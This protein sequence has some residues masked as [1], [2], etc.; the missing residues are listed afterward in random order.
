MATKNSKKPTKAKKPAAKKVTKV[1]KTSKES[2]CEETSKPVK[3]AAAAK[4]APK[5][6]AVKVSASPTDF[7]AFLKNFQPYRSK[8]SEKYMNKNQQKHF[9][10]MLTAW[11][12]ALIE[13]QEKTEQLIQ[14]D[15]SNFPDSLDRAAKEEEFMLELRKEK[16]NENS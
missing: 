14:Q 2:P 11:K 9:L 12:E 15:Q 1:Q 4:K 13:E 8:K 3:K 10:G 6:A 16:E 5:K 7:S